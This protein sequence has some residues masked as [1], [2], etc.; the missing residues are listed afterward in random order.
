MDT[1][2]LWATIIS[3]VVGVIAII[4]ALII[5]RRS[6]NETKQQIRAVYN[7]LDVFVASQNPMMMEAKKKYELQIE[8]LNQQIQKLE[9]DIQCFSP[10]FGRGAR[11]DDCDELYKKE[12]QCE[13]LEGLENKRNEIQDYLDLIN[14]YLQKAKNKDGI[15]EI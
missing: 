15:K 2:L 12:K 5:A 8:G 13:Q 6:S 10:Y 3:P 4:V 9:E 7:I 1:I 11:V 14:A